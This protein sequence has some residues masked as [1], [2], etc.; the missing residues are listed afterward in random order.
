MPAEVVF[1][2]PL[3][4]L[5]NDLAKIPEGNKFVYQLEELTPIELFI[6][7][8]EITYLLEILTCDIQSDVKFRIL[9]VEGLVRLKATVDA[10]WVTLTPADRIANIKSRKYRYNFS[11]N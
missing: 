2:V 9:Q 8:S 5:G 6:R 1:H 11:K 7:M 4:I 3:G 10:K